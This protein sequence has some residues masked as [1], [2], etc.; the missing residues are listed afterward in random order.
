MTVSVRAVIQQ[1]AILSSIQGDL[2]DRRV[3]VCGRS[4]LDEAMTGLGVID[5]DRIRDRRGR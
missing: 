5:G 2:C 4:L 3:V 1:L